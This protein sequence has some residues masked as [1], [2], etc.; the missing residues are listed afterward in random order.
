M[1]IYGPIG[2]SWFDDNSWDAASFVREFNRVAQEHDRINIHINSPGGIIDEGLPIFNVI[3]SCEKDTH[4]Y[5]DGIAYS[6]GAIIALA[7][8]TV[9]AAKNSLMLFHNASGWASGN[10]QDFRHTADQLDRYD[11]SLITSLYSKTGLTEDEI[12]Q[13]YFDFTDHLL[14]AD[15]ARQAG[16][17]DIIEDVSA[18]TPENITALSGEELFA[19]FLRQD[20]SDPLLSR[21]KDFFRDSFSFTHKPTSEMDQPLIAI[22]SALGLDATATADQIVHSITGLNARI[23]ELTRS[24]QAASDSLNMLT[25]A[26]AAIDESIANA[27]DLA[28]KVTALN[29]FI[30]GLENSDATTPTAAVKEKDQ[31]DP[32]DPDPAESFEHNRSADKF[33]S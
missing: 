8:K 23:T 7:A 3:Q 1:Y 12:R 15:E 22:A 18:N 21:L 13:K 25:A 14:T 30:T 16:F 6:M 29:A 9:H 28:A 26:I 27:T 19:Y 33:L 11:S 10:A 5:I 31:I 2:F 32:I 4:T 20:H 17:I 24:S